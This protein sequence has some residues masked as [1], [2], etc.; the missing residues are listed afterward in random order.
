MIGNT[1]ANLIIVAVILFL[2]FLVAVSVTLANR[3]GSEHLNT[4]WK[5]IL[6]PGVTTLSIP[7]GAQ[8]LSVDVQNG[9]VCLWALVNPNG[10]KESRDF[11]SVSTGEEIAGKYNSLNFVGTVKIENAFHFHIFELSR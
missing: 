5:F 7:V 11:I 6:E 1:E 4:V 3:K 9:Q 10:T 2:G 8:V